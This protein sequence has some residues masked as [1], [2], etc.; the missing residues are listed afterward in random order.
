MIIITMIVC[1]IGNVLPTTVLSARNI[2]SI[3]KQSQFDDLRS[4]LTVDGKIFV[5]FC[6]TYRINYAEMVPF[7]LARRR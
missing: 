6:G 3:K 4:L 1:D 5:D 7:S 2:L